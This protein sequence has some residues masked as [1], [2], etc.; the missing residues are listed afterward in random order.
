MIS[1]KKILNTQQIRDAD[2]Y[3]IQNKPIGSIDLMENAANAFV[4]CIE[5]KIDNG[6]MAI[7]CG[8]GNNGGDGLA[9]ARILKNRNILVKCF[10]VKHRTECTADCQINLERLGQVEFIESENNLP[11][12]A[13]FTLVID[14]LLGSGL[15]GEVSGL[16]ARV[17]DR[18]NETAQQIISIDLPSGLPSD[19]IAQSQSII[20]ADLA[21][22]FQ[23]PKWSFFMPENGSFVKEWTTVEIGLNEDFIQNQ[24]TEKYVLDSRIEHWVKP[25]NRFSHKGTYGHALIMAGS[26]GKMGAAVLSTRGCMRAGAGLTTAY[27]PKCGYQI[28]QIAAPEAMC[29]TDEREERLAHLPNTEIYSAI[30]IGP[31]L[32]VDSSTASMVRQLLKNTLQPKVLDADALNILAENKDL[33]NMLD[34]SCILTP[35]IKEFDRLVGY[36]SNSLERME[37]QLHF[38]KKHDCIVVLKDA[39][40]II[41]TPDGQQFVNTTG[42]A[43]M[44]TGGSGDVLTGI[45]TGLLAQ[46]YSGVEVSLIGVYFHGKAGDEASKRKGQS[47]LLAG[48]IIDALRIEGGIKMSQKIF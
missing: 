6:Q 17:I 18:I 10:L 37:K 7:V 20:R 21:V 5:N 9:V 34:S 26:Y 38:S 15:T 13:E 23:R 19:G 30:A 4:H 11:N 43:G 35:H 41:S 2:N 27:V 29:M 25:R 32:G 46:G 8:M 47:A 3:T 14:A 39:H 31:G 12:F 22:S 28:M 40:T 16:M 33:L 45:L 1:L 36:S 44:A 48:D 24:T 42:N